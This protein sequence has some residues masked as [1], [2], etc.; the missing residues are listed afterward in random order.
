MVANKQTYLKKILWAFVLMLTTIQASAQEKQLIQIKTFDQQLQVVKNIEISVNGKEYVKI[1]SKGTGFLEIMDNEL[2]LKSIKIKNEELEAA[3][4]NLSKGIIEIIIRKKNYRIIEYVLKD[5][6]NNPIPNL[7]V[8]FNGKKISSEITN[9]EGKI[10]IPLAI[11]EK[12]NLT[13]KFAI[14]NYKI[15]N[16][17]SIGGENIITA[18]K[19]VISPSP[20]IFVTK[21]S[22]PGK[23]YFKDFDISKLDSIQSLTVFYAIFKNYQIKDMSSAAKKKV[24][25]KFNALVQQL[26]DSATHRSSLSGKISDSSFVADDIKNLLKQAVEENKTL[27]IQR[28]DFDQQIKLIAEK[29]DAGVQNLDPEARD[30]LLSQLS[31]LE[32][33]LLKNEN[34][35]YKNQSDYRQVVSTFKE[36]FLDFEDVE[37]QLS[38]SEAQRLADQTV[39]T[40]TIIIVLFIVFVF[41]LLIILLISFSNKLRNQ[42]KELVFANDEVKRINEN[43]E[44]LVAKRT[45]LLEEANKELDTFLYRASHDLRSPVCSIIGLCNIAIMDTDNNPKEILGKVVDTTMSMDKLLK[46][47]SIISEI[48]QPVNFSLINL[49]N[50]VERLKYYYNPVISRHNIKFSI[51]CPD[52]LIIYSNPNLVETILNN[53]IENAIFYTALKD[54]SHREIKIKGSILNHQLAISVYDNGLGINTEMT[55]K[56]FDM[57]FKGNENSKGNGLGLYIVNR[58][59]KALDGTI[60]VDSALGSFTKFDIYLPLMEMPVAAKGIEA[61]ALNES[62]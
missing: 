22:T 55:N 43:L 59:V 8:N 42:K 62:F 16:V 37:F 17:K 24:D 45:F 26:Q 12:E 1:G 7:K 50:T 44:T 38:L 41:G 57:F 40:R 49:K 60:T 10:Q 5:V 47:L 30:R 32:I 58:S 4:W 20:E 18:E 28:K 15:I 14:N 21:K 11:D 48:N 6:N 9:S 31:S 46:K 34:L 61:K 3:S 56:L 29:L 36:K 52:Y 25:A 51:D 39:F 33:L 53:L 13:D 27:E 35:F 23:D 2:P 54:S 19:I